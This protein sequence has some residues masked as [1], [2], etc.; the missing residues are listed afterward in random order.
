MAACHARARTAE[1]TDWQRIVLLY[2]A[3]LQLTRSPIVALNRA[4]AVAMAQGQPLGSM[5][6]IPRSRTLVILRW[7]ATTCFPMCAET[8]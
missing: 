5:R 7:R 4:V 8:C 2:D 1:E 3:L 6:S